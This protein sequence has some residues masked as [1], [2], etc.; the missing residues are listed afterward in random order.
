MPQV[1]FL[2]LP[3]QPAEQLDH[4]GAEWGDAFIRRG[5]VTGSRSTAASVMSAHSEISRTGCAR[6][7]L[8]PAAR[9]PNSRAIHRQVASQPV[10]AR[11]HQDDE[12]ACLS[13]AADW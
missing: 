3:V 5:Q 12:A 6:E 2:P 10:E 1:S 8:C 11:F 9:Q 4:T 13:T 7:P